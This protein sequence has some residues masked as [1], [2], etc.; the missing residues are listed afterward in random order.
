MAPHLSPY[1]S[2]LQVV[3]QC[4]GSAKTHPGILT[5]TAVAVDLHHIEE[6]YA[7]PMIDDMDGMYSSVMI[8]CV[9]SQY[10]LV[11]ATWTDLCNQVSVV[12]TRWYSR[13]EVSVRNLSQRVAATDPG[14]TSGASWHLRFWS[15]LS[16]SYHPDK[17][18][19]AQTSTRPPASSWRAKNLWLASSAST[20][21]RWA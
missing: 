18:W 17:L 11:D 9:V 21:K 5:F 8:L 12:R 15:F 10:Y 3:V 7:G 4:S 1:Y 20:T 19:L 13:K 14:L 16:L 6:K 2:G